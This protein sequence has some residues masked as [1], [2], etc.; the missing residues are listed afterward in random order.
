M[1]K[2]NKLFLQV[3]TM[4]G[5]ADIEVSKSNVAMNAY[6]AAVLLTCPYKELTKKHF[7]PLFFWC[8][9]EGHGAKVF[10]KNLNRGRSLFS[11][12]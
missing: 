10:I 7:N 1:L 4:I 5:R 11:R 6:L 2:L 8:H 9:R 12:Y 3:V